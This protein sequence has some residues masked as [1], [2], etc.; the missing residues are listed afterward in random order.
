MGNLGIRSLV[1]GAWSGVGAVLWARGLAVWELGYMVG[2][3]AGATENYLSWENPCPYIWWPGM[4][5][6]A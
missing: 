3:S 1:A 5:D 6:S 4:K 2:H